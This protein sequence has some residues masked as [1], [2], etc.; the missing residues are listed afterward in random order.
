MLTPQLLEALRGLI[1]ININLPKDS[2]PSYDQTKLP[3]SWRP[4][5]LLGPDALAALGIDLTAGGAATPPAY[6][7]LILD[8]SVYGFVKANGV[9]TLTKI[10]GAVV[11]IVG[12]LSAIGCSALAEVSG[13]SS[14]AQLGGNLMLTSNGLSQSE[15]DWVL[16]KLLTVFGPDGVTLWGANGQ[17]VNVTGLSAPSATGIGDAATLTARGATV[18]YND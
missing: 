3:F 15:V 8:Q 17:T 13:L 12:D 1:T 4:T 5:T 9:L 14:L 18:V 2:M 6:T 11:T 16:H 10:L 7:E